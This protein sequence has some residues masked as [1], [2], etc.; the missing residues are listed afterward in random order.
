MNKKYKNTIRASFLG[1]AVQAIGNNFAPLL[2]L[3]FQNTF[4]ISLSKITFLIT[5]T[6]FIQLLTDLMA[7]FIVD[8]LGVRLLAVI[9]HLLC[10]IG[11]VSL[12]FL[13]FMMSNTYSALLISVCIYSVGCG[14]LEVI[15]SP[16]VESCPSDNKEQTMS[17]LHSFY[18]FGNV[19]VVLL[20]TLYFIFVGIEYWMYLCLL[21]A[22]IPMINAVVF[23]FVLVPNVNEDVESGIIFKLFKNKL[24]W[25]FALVMICAGASEIGM[26]QWASSFVESALGVSK[27]MG[28]LFGAM[29]FALMMAVSRIYFGK[30]G[31]KMDLSSFMKRSSTLC[32]VCYLV[33]AITK[34][35]MIGLLGVIVCGFSV[36][37]LWPGTY[38][39]A[40]GS[41][42]GSG[43][44][45]FA[46]LALAGDIGCTT[47]PSV[48][49]FVSS[50]FDN[51]LKFGILFASIFPLLLFISL[52]VIESYKK[53]N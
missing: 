34:S 6:F 4:D 20:S 39:L 22:I 30:Y 47:G 44:T 51:N 27:S 52:K 31:D 36:G 21:W 33:M 28:D 48:I 1:L 8:K 35:P 19:F 49:G 38:S 45:L 42:K 14:M 15:M 12:G 25:Y 2:F 5:I 53:T 7:I 3:T 10:G 26:S 16:I 32:F 37:I 24:F 9:S 29:T 23:M 50:I 46:M 41:L 11:L 17:M 13:P 40:S 43:T 18:S